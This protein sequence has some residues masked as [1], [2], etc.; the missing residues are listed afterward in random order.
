[1]RQTLLMAASLAGL[2]T[3]SASAGVLTVPPTGRVLTELVA[4]LVASDASPVARGQA[5]FR[6]LESG[7]VA[8]QLAVEDMSGFATG[9][10]LRAGDRIVFTLT[11][12]PAT[13]VHV[14]GL[15]PLTDEE[16]RLFHDEALV[17]EV[18]TAAHPE[19][20][21]GGRV[22]LL[23]LPETT[24][25]CTAGDPRV[26]KH[27]VRR[28]V[29]RLP[30][31]VRKTAPVKSLLRSSRR[32]ACGPPPRREKPGRVACCVAKNP[33]GNL[34]IEPLCV[35]ATAA[36]CGRLGGT[37]LAETSCWAAMPCG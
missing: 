18:E 13:G 16:Q 5:T 36:Q 12:P 20:E 37:T 3:A 27:C 8:W 17:L 19:G 34:V 2:V 21:I 4:D 33:I 25:D 35:P 9:V 15:G 31:V 23:H 6:M 14:G 22:R 29:K 10:H 24:C 28:G 7:M 32:A 26:F 1:M 11:N 30:R